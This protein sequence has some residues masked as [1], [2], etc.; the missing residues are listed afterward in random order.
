MTNKY[1]TTPVYY[2]NDIPHIGHAYTTIAADVLNRYYKQQGDSS[3]FL[4]GTDEHG[5]KIAEAADKAGKEPQTFVDDL[6][7]QF[8]KAWE[9]LDIKY[10]GF[11]RTTDKRHENVVVE[12]IEKLKEAGYV[13]KRKYE[14]LYC[15][16]CEKFIAGDELEEGKCPHHGKKPVKHSEENY[17]F[18]LS[19]LEKELLGVIETGELEIAPVSRKNEIVGKIKKGLED[20]SISRQAV[21][22]GVKFPGDDSQTVYVW[23]DALINY[24]S[25]AKIFDGITWPAD[26]HL[27]GKDILWFHAV[28]WPAMLIAIGEKL[29]KKVFAHGFFTIGGKKM[30]KSLGN[31]IDP[32]T[33]TSKYGTDA[34]RYAILREFPFGEDGDISEEKIAEKY[35]NDLSNELGNLLQRNLSMIN[36]Y[37]VKIEKTKPDDVGD[38]QKKMMENLE[39]EKRLET[40]WEVVKKDNRFIE[41]NKPW[42]LAKTDSKKLQSIL[43]EV[44]DSLVTVAFYLEPFMPKTAGKMKKQLDTLKPEPLF[45][46]LEG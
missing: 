10:D 17:F 42:E 9:S 27:I 5:A 19:R 33:L 22:W 7:P 36:K 39:F 30:S 21:K 29:P 6:A 24:Y 23:V 35:N 2:V 3:F 1:I 18:L 45:P 16:G 20:V 40:I 15:V 41:E 43:Q 8:K 11:I 31:V 32:I 25:A 46:R 37:K 14:G 12:F 26:L 13:E 4:T 34:V 38:C 28:I 44:Y